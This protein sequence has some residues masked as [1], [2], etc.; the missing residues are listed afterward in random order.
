MKNMV[1]R[2]MR[3]A[4]SI[5]KATDTHSEYVVLIVFPL[6]QWSRER[7]SMSPYTY[8]ACL[9]SSQCSVIVQ[10]MSCRSYTVGTGFDSNPV[11]VRLMVGK[12]TSFSPNTSAPP[13]PVTIVPTTLH[14]HPH[15]HL[16]PTRSTNGPSLGTLQK[17]MLFGKSLHSRTGRDE[18]KGKTQERMERGS[19]K[20]SS[21]AGSEKMERVGGR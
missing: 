21:S 17:G 3:F 16:S 13:P 14:S 4:C 1:E 20:R 12:L 7:A 5:P 6:Q 10:V 15:L 18:K 2:R 11:R 9:D 19:R 8:I